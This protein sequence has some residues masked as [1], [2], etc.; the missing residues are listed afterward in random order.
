MGQYI[1]TV[2]F[3]TFDAGPKID[4]RKD[5]ELVRRISYTTTPGRFSKYITKAGATTAMENGYAGVLLADDLWE[6]RCR[7]LCRCSRVEAR[8]SSSSQHTRAGATAAVDDAYAGALLA[9]DL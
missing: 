6:C 5:T 3:F 2:I 9:D 4:T 8:S 1:E 7:R